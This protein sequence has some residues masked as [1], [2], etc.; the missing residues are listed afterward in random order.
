[1]SARAKTSGRHL[2]GPV[3]ERADLDPRRRD[4]AGCG[5]G[6]V[7]DKLAEEE[8]ERA[9]AERPGQ[10][11]A[12]RV[13][14]QLDPVAAT[15]PALHLEAQRRDC[16]RQRIL[17][18]KRPHLPERPKERHRRDRS[19]RPRPR[20]SPECGACCAPIS[21]VKSNMSA[22]HHHAARRGIRL[23]RP[24]PRRHRCRADCRCR[25]CRQRLSVPG[26]RK[27]PGRR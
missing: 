1:M 15:G 27:G 17:A 24:T 23:P 7:C 9:V 16:R 13:Q 5:Q 10:F 19:C 8:D 20:R 22:R 26:R 21:S 14:Q 3:A 18:Q 25:W 2:A 4:E 11:A 12:R 6:V